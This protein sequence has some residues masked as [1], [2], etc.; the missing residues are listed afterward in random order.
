[1]ERLKRFMATNYADDFAEL[2]VEYGEDWGRIGEALGTLPSRAR[3]NWVEFGGDVA[4]HS[5]WT[6]DEARQLQLLTG[7][8]V[9]PKEA[10][11]LLGIKIQKVRERKIVAAK[12]T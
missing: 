5:A 7:S 12:A 3:R 9:R 8:G 10:A 4:S 1:M 11:R 6:A 2:V